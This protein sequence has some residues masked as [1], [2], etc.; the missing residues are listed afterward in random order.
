M[1]GAVCVQRDVIHVNSVVA[2]VRVDR[3][4]ARVPGPCDPAPGRVGAQAGSASDR[5]VL[6][7]EPLDD[8]CLCM[9][10]SFGT[11]VFANAERL[12]T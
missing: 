4:L 12:M 3:A 11:R 7:Q 6:A 8:V 5:A 9:D 10:F 1:R 2:T